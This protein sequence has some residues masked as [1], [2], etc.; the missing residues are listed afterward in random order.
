MRTDGA[1]APISSGIGIR[2]VKMV[3]SMLKTRGYC[4]L[5]WDMVCFYRWGMEESNHTAKR[6]CEGRSERATRRVT[7]KATQ[8]DLPFTRTIQ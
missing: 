6:E 8:T 4:L 3:V 1:P 7:K 5:C 2:S